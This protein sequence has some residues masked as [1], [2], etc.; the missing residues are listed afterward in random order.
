MGLGVINQTIGLPTA[1]HGQ[2]IIQTQEGG[3]I[4]VGMDISPLKCQSVMCCLA[5]LHWQYIPISKKVFPP[6]P[7][8][9]VIS[10]V[11]LTKHKQEACAVYGFS[12]EKQM[13]MLRAKVAEI[14]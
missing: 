11:Y 2:K 4:N 13:H 5:F 1:P 3:F 7:L 8:E 14:K 10:R 6:F 12:D 9:A